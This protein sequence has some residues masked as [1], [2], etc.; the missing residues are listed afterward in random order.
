MEGKSMG[1]T[2]YIHVC[3]LERRP[4]AMMV[5]ICPLRLGGRI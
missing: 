2:L 3:T 5:A 4:L 1:A